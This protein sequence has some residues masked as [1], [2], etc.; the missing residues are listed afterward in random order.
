VLVLL[1][2]GQT[3]PDYSLASLDNEHAPWTSAVLGLIRFPLTT[4]VEI[5]GVDG[6]AVYSVANGAMLVCLDKQLAYRESYSAKY[7]SAI[8]KFTLQIG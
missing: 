1:L 4:P 8:R 6:K 5:L 3:N 7:R 2:P